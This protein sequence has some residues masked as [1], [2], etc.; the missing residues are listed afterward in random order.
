M[1]ESMSSYLSR[2]VDS[3]ELL[4]C[5]HGLKRLDRQVF[6]TVAATAES[7][8]VDDIA[9]AVDRERSTAYRS[10]QRLLSAGL[11]TE[12]QVNYDQGGYYHVYHAA[13]ADEVADEMQRVL[14][15]WYAE[16]G[17]LIAGFREE[18]ADASESASSDQREGEP[19][20]DD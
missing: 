19:E 3:D 18:F 7:M 12:E 9:A 17:Q 16:M 5:V 14:N 8:T 10:V 13:D 11:L 4:E 6:R 1:T 20:D 15:D 2:D